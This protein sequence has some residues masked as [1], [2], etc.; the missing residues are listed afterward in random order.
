MTEPLMGEQ[1]SML[2]LVSP[3][4]KTYQEHSAAIKEKTSSQSSKLSATSAMKPFLFLDLG[5]G[6]WSP[7]GCIVGKGYSIAWR[8]LD[9]QYYGVPQRRKRIYLVADFGSE[10]AGEIQ[11]VGESMPWNPETCGE[12]WESAA[13]YVEG[14]TDGSGQR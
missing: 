6:N 14:S 7:A 3:F 13:R 5:G 9:A 11:F 10:R 12:A 2:D 4:G 1:V 8:V